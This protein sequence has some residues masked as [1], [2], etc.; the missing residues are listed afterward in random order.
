MRYKRALISLVC[1]FVAGIG[2]LFFLGN[3]TVQSTDLPQTDNNNPTVLQADDVY[4]P[5][6]VKNADH[7]D[8]IA[9]QNAIDA[10]P[11]TGGQVLI[12]TGTF[13]CTT[14]IVIARRNVELRGQGPS[15]IL[16][17]ADGSNSPVLVIGDLTTP[18][19]VT[20]QNIRISDLT[21]DGNRAHQTEECWGGPCDSGGLTAI[22]NNGITVRGV[23]DVQ[24]E[25]VSVFRARSGGLVTEKGCQRLFISGFSSTDNYFDGIAAYETEN[26]IFSGLYLYGNPFAGLSLDIRFNNNIVSNAIMANNGKQGVF[27]RDSRDNVFSDIQIRGSGEQGLFL[28]QVD[29]DVTRPASGNTFHGL[30]VSDSAQAGM[31]VNDASCVDNLVV[32]AQFINNPVCISEQTPGL[33]EQV[34]IICR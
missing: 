29:S 6:V 28:A 18:P 19:M 5:I 25:R 4:L 9:I 27:M 22:R 20:Y 7:A 33:V 8:C 24:I 26:S 30:V 1:L 15:T 21:I 31:R 16:F 32:G 23:S 12:S 10:L 3:E 11:E 13:T 17:L 2:A 14:A 34:G